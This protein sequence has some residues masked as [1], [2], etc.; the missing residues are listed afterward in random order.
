M[1]CRCKAKEEMRPIC[2]YE[3]GTFEGYKTMHVLYCYKCGRLAITEDGR[4]DFADWYE[5][6]ELAK[7]R[8]A[9]LVAEA[10]KKKE[11][12]ERKEY[13]R[14]KAKYDND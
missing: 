4:S 11:A 9:E 1:K 8:K 6:E 5:P 10:K 3:E 13:A 12:E 7:K 14:L 2:R